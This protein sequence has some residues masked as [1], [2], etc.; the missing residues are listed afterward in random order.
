[1]TRLVRKILHING[2]SS[3]YKMLPAKL[4]DAKTGMELL[5]FIVKYTFFYTSKRL[6]QTHLQSDGR[7]YEILLS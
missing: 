3:Q 5:L 2:A 6:N 7:K 1:M 4:S